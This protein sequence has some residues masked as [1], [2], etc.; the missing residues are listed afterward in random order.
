ME[1]P[2][3][4]SH[5]HDP[6]RL[7]VLAST[8]LLDS[9]PEEAFDRL[10]RLA[11]RLVGTPA[12][13]INFI[14]TRRQFF[15]SDSRPGEAGSAGGDV[16]L[17]HS[18]CQYVVADQQALIVEDARRDPVLSSNGATLSGAVVS[19]VG[20]P[21]TTSDGFTLG[22]LCAFD[23][24]PRA[25]AE[26]DVALLRE[27]AALTLTEIELR[28]N[29]RRL[30]ASYAELQ[31]LE[32]QRGELVDMLVHDLRNPLTAILGGLDLIACASD[33]GEKT[34]EDVRIAQDGAEAVVEMVSEILDVSRAQAGSLGLSIAP[35]T[36]REV[37]TSAVG[38]LQ[39]LADKQGVRLR[40]ASPLPST[41]L[42][43]DAGKLGRVF[44]NLI[45]NAIQHS[46]TGAEVVVGAVLDPSGEQMVFSVRDHGGG[47]PPDVLPRLFEKFQT[48]GSRL[49][50]HAS[51]GLGL[52]F[53]KLAVEAH[54][55][56]IRAENAE[57]GGALVSFSL[58]VS[59]LKIRK[60]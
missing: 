24:T 58:P 54:G 3:R 33:L 15:K 42:H 55:G 10:T 19:Y 1:T 8:E 45:A 12:A 43:V 35:T 4:A 44:V 2:P 60:A 25:W 48:G 20:V 41:T 29:A 5:L 38:R 6:K 56:T 14:D 30:Q 21:L 49:S 17:S 26:E 36:A 22:S 23:T 37:I 57:G 27:L 52:S 31:K 18:F 32:L 40:T 13:Q 51:T 28:R 53:C 59:P 7:E 47:I 50:G 11:A 34:L 46:P 16:P 9:A 39:Q